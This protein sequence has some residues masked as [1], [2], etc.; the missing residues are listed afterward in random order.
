L[1]TTKWRDALA[2]RGEHQT[3]LDLVADNVPR[4]RKTRRRRES[5]VKRRKKFI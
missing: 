3:A 2:A 4:V 1:E 5:T